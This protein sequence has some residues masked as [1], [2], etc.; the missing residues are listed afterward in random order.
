MPNP[1]R[2][3]S[4]RGATARIALGFLLLGLLALCV[5]A[6]PALGDDI[7]GQK[8]RGRRAASTSSA[9]GSRRSGSSEEALRNEIDGV[10]A[11]IRQ[12]EASVGDVSLQLSTLE[13]DLALHRE[14]L[15][16]LNKLY[17]APV[18][19]A[20]RAA[21]GSTPSRSRVSIAASSRST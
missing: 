6:T 5:L 12:L 1:C 10:T 19:P 14:R 9:P 16:K 7:L 4:L 11:R 15:A 8:Q 20:G 2:V 13:Q 17:Q 3:T 18:E 21:A